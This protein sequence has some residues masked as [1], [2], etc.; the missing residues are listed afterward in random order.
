MNP[1]VESVSAN[2]YAFAAAR[3][4]YLKSTC[5]S[6]AV[7][8]T[9]KLFDTAMKMSRRLSLGIL[10]AR[11][12]I[13]TSTSYNLSIAPAFVT[14]LGPGSTPADTTNTY[15]SP[16]VGGTCHVTNA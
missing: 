3:T 1:S 5:S 14:W 16:D 11:I 2:M 9:S 12:A 7:S 13:V 8:Y 10:G 15:R 6:T 4:G